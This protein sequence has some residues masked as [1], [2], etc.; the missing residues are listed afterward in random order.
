MHT[1]PVRLFVAVDLPASIVRLIRSLPRPARSGL[2]WTTPSTWHVTLRF[3]G[4][5]DDPQP[6][7]EA[8]SIIPS[9]LDAHPVEARLGPTTAWFPGGRVLHLPVTGV[10]KLAG[11]VRDA[12]A[13]WGPHEEPAFAGH[14]TLARFSGPGPGPADLAGTP[15]AAHFEVPD[16]VLYASSLGS[17]GA[18]YEVVSSVPIITDHKI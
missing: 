18:T 6:L 2:R 10:E 9:G 3:L 13:R 4:D 15:V 12:T 17:G 16:V 8:L 7:V 1:G 14:V 11:V 5:V